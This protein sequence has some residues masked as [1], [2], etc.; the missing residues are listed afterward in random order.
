MSKISIKLK[1]KIRKILKKMGKDD[2]KSLLIASCILY[3]KE[4]YGKIFM[5]RNVL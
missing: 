4:W 5:Y 2:I 1:T 3:S